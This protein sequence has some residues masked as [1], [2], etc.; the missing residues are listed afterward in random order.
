M[1]RWRDFPMNLLSEVRK[2]AEDALLL[3]GGGDQ[4]EV[5][6]GMCVLVAIGLRLESLEASLK[7]VHRDD[8]PTGSYVLWQIR[9][10]AV[11]RAITREIVEGRAQAL[12]ERGLLTWV[13]EGLHSLSNPDSAYE[14]M[15]GVDADR[16]KK[17]M[18][19][20]LSYL[21]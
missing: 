6:T 20:R 17:E 21:L 5:V 2:S 10:L 18:T 16:L 19:K 13:R 4:V 11:L 8:D 14:G 1:F 3:V 9:V 12:D 15:L 7:D